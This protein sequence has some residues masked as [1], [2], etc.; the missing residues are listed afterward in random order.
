M[1]N[2]N[3]FGFS[4]IKDIVDDKAKLVRTT[5]V[6]DFENRSKLLVEYGKGALVFSNGEYQVFGEGRYSLNDKIGDI[7]ASLRG[8]LWFVGVG[9]KIKSKMDAAK[10]DKPKQK[11][12]KKT[13]AAGFEIS[14]EMMQMMGGF[15]VLRLTSMMGMLNIAFTKEEL[16][17]MNKQL[18]KIRKPKK[19]QK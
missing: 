8:K 5:E 2:P 6:K 9:L 1:M 4:V 13:K 15:T 7:F 18:N 12:D 14:P 17:T 16:L 11:K 19:L 3:R 10:G